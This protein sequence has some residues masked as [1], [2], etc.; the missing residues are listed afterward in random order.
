MDTHRPTRPRVHDV[1]NA[2]ADRAIYARLYQLTAEAAGPAISLALARTTAG[3]AAELA[4]KE[5]RELQVFLLEAE[6]PRGN[7]QPA[8][9]HALFGG[10]QMYL[11][12][13]LEKREDPAADETLTRDLS[14]EFARVLWSSWLR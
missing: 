5:L 9:H 7:N 12:E 6:Q 10:L 2:R 1:R 4:H 8:E 3:E 13:S 11:V 14:E